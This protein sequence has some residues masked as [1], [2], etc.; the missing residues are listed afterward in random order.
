MAVAIKTRINNWLERIDQMELR[1]RLLLLATAVIVLFLLVDTLLLQPMLK[2]QQATQ[3]AISEL[4]IKLNGLRQNAQLYVYKS[5]KDP[6]ESRRVA[7]AQLTRELA[8]LDA[9]IVGQLGALVEPAQAAEVLEQVLSSH[10]R[11]ELATLSA[12][13]KGLDNPDAGQPAASTGLARYQ[14]DMVVRGNYLD[15]LVYLQNLEAMPWKFFWQQVEFQASEYPHAETRIK[16]YTLGAE[17][18]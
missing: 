12:S 18:V 11:L 9:R 5:E 3:A 10:P 7:Q 1:E 6:L 15:L 17:D 14:L 13:T 4:E 8:D 16:L 2:A